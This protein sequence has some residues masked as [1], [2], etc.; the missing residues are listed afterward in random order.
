M[1]KNLISKI[2]LSKNLNLRVVKNIIKNDNTNYDHLLKRN[3]KNLNNK[4][5]KTLV[6]RNEK[7]ELFIINWGPYSCSKIHDHAE[8]G[9]VM[10]VIQGNLTEYIYNTNLDLKTFENYSVN[11]TTYKIILCYHKIENNNSYGATSI[12]IYSPPKYKTRYFN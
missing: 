5:E 2:N 10:K 8:E 1:L 12:H 9:C 7:Y 3:M 4:Y 6:Y 11:D